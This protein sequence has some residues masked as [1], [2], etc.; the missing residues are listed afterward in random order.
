MLRNTN[1]TTAS[2]QGHRWRRPRLR[3]WLREQDGDKPLIDTIVR[4]GRQ[5]HPVHQR[6]LRGDADRDD[7]SVPV[8]DRLSSEIVTPVD[9]P[10]SGY[11]AAFQIGIAA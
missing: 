7:R 2:T 9:S 4:D 6:H 8:A 1:R 3:V 10:S 11:T 5:R